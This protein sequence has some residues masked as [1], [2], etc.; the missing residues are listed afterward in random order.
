MS[1]YPISISASGSIILGPD[2]VCDGFHREK[3]IRVQTHIHDDHM[4]DFNTSKQF[5]DIY[6]TQAT[7]DL[8]AAEYNADL[9]YRCKEGGNFYIVGHNL[10][11]KVNGSTIELVHNNHMLGSAQVAIEYK[12]GLRL[13][14]SS[15]FSWPIESI[16]QVEALVVDSTAGQGS[17]RH[18]SQGEIEAKYVDLINTRLGFGPVNVKA[19]RGTLQRGMQ[20]L[21]G[22]T[23]YP[24]IGSKKLCGEVEVYQRHGYGIDHLIESTSQE[25][26]EI[27]KNSKHIRFFGKGD[28][29]PIDF[30]KAS[31]ITLSAYMTKPDEPILE[32]SERSYSVALSNHADFNE[33]LEYVKNT[34]AKFV[35]TDNSRNGHSHELASEIRNSLGIEAIA[36]DCT[37]SHEWGE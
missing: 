16:I 29:M 17:K 35:V 22:A 8:L 9:A 1:K 15:D 19:H 11:I 33:T 27:I 10:P 14:Y 31:T 26:V 37:C 23:T 18:F 6:L 7:H 5:Q 21:S 3:K 34:N 12:N 13:G 36:A 25:G 4:A 28:R 30:G 24:M 20:A 2:L 32:F